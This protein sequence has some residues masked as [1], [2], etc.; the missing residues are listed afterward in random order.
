MC[1]FHIMYV[2]T[3]NE[4]DGRENKT[5]SVQIFTSTI[6]LRFVSSIPIF[7]KV[8]IQGF[9]HKIA[10]TV[11]IFPVACFPFACITSVHLVSLSL[12]SQLCFLHSNWNAE[13]KSTETSHCLAEWKRNGSRY[14]KTKCFVIVSK[15][16]HATFA[17]IIFI[18]EVIA[19]PIRFVF[20][21]I[22]CR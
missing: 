12:F 16:K 5:I 11:P 17:N 22:C 15:W 20:S 14:S 19:R 2:S 4:K 8:R 9:V 3:R 13:N 7:W 21:Q 10:K 6:N 18:G 1:M